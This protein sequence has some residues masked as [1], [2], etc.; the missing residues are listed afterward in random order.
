MRHLIESLDSAA[1]DSGTNLV[2]GGVTLEG[3]ENARRLADHLTSLGRGV[4]WFDGFPGDKRAHGPTD[5]LFVI[6]YGERERNRRLNRLERERTE[7]ISSFIEYSVTPGTDTGTEHSGPTGAATTMTDDAGRFVARFLKRWNTATRGYA[8][9]RLIRGE[10][11]ALSE[12]LTPEEIFYCDD[13]AL[14]AAWHAARLWPAT[15]VTR[16][17][18]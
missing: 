3:F 18:T 17:P 15:P 13:H 5:G 1:P 8:S 6:D 4:V 16:A 2:F 9:W 14:T 11:V 10:V 7:T 12:R